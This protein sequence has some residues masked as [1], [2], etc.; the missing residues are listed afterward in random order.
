M[1]SICLPNQT[2][3]VTLFMGFHTKTKTKIKQK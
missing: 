3:V 1:D 2:E